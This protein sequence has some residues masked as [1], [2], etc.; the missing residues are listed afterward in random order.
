[1]ER[2]LEPRRRNPVSVDRLLRLRRGP[3]SLGPERRCH[4]R[5][6]P[7]RRAVLS[8]ASSL[9]YRNNDNGAAYFRGAIVIPWHEISRTRDYSIAFCAASS[10]ART[11]L[12]PVP[13]STSRSSTD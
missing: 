7:V 3:V 6:H 4:A 8:L 10:C 12:G 9:L 1:M 2:R 13:P 5:A 11:A